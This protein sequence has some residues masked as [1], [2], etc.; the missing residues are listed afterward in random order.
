MNLDGILSNAASG[1]AASSNALAVIAHN[2]ANA[3][4]PD[5]TEESANQSSLG[6]GFG[7]RVGATSRDIDTQLQ[8]ATFAQNAAV[9]S[10]T[11]RQQALTGIDAVQ[12]QTGSGDDISGLLA[13]LQASFTALE[14]DPSNQTQQ[15]AVVAAAATLAS[16]INRVAGNVGA[17][18]QNA[19]DD[20]VAA[21]AN[22]NTAL[23]QVGTLSDSIVRAQAAGLSTADLESSRD[24]AIDTVNN[25]MPVTEVAQSTGDVMLIASGG[26]VL[27]TR[28]SMT[29]ALAPA[30]LG[31]GAGATAA[32]PALTLG[33]TDITAQVSG[34]R[35]G[36]DLTLRDS[37]MPL[38]QA[39]LDEFAHTL[40]SRFDQQGLTLFS[41]AS[42]TVPA[43]GGSPVQSGYLGFATTIQVNPVA[44]TTPS[45]VRDGL[46]G[47]AATTPSGR[48][49]D[50]SLISAVL[51]YTFG[52]EQS[53]GVIQPPPS[54]T[55]L[56][57]SG[58][59][60]LPYAAA[61]SLSGFATTLVASMSGDVS[62]TADQLT[63]ATALQSTLQGQLSSTSGVSI[64]QEM[65][66]MVQIQ[67]AYAANG[68]VI[69][70]V[71][72]MWTSLLA[73]VT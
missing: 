33:G 47:A 71:Q 42:G 52:T 16:Q 65:A 56:G 2:V 60:E 38:Y 68:K 50:T 6:D 61:T 30:T 14:T 69:T 3:K 20:A 1:I 26:V 19:Q 29:V 59:L 7:V 8:A 4:T 58:T 35:L 46:Q 72:D 34:G 9:A 51:D 27:P 53:A 36:S 12:G 21:V 41:D 39:G 32:A 18:R 15:S 25:I 31:T 70:A 37:T 73:T 67:N 48:S 17:A 57:A 40:A 11:T 23:Q 13:T 49:G 64:D 44:T 45:V 24:A 63:T 62:D 10:L 5:Y 43:G 28:G 22:L 54:T 66:N 55:G